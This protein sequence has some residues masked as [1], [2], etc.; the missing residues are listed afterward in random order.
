MSRSDIYKIKEEVK[1]SPYV[2]P[3]LLI[4]GRGITFN[5]IEHV[6]LNS[7]H[8]NNEETIRAI[9][10]TSRKREY[11]EVRQVIFYFAYIYL[12]FYPLSQIGK[13]YKRN[14]ATVLHSVKV[15]KCL[16]ETNKSFNDK[17]QGINTLL[18]NHLKHVVKNEML[19]SEVLLTQKRSKITIEDYGINDQEVFG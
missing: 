16:C 12:K 18:K 8:S 2:L 10:S 5:L 15:V 19:E 11:A 6:V 7:F 1:I 17:I 9:K 13:K 14:H 3:G 4:P